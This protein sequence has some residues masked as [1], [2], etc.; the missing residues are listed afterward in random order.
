MIYVVLG[1]HKSGTTLVSR[2]LHASGIDMGDV[3]P[4]VDYDAGNKYERA[5]CLALNLEIL[6]TTTY[7]VIDLAPGRAVADERQ[8]ARMDD[9]VARCQ[10]RHADWGIKDPRLCLTYGLWR[11]HLP[12]HR[13]I[14]VYRDPAQV[15]PR[16]KWR[17]RR[18]FAVNLRRAAAYQRRWIEHNRGVLDA[19]AATDLPRIVLSYH[20]LMTGPEE[21]ARLEA[22]VGRPL[23][24]CRE[25]GLYRSR[26]RPD[27]NLK[28]AG[29]WLDVRHGLRCADV[30][31][32]LAALRQEELAAGSA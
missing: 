6:G 7:D 17:G 10:A 18:G 11:P 23:A 20:E 4:D 21:F 31:A 30:L 16:F 9:L 8:Q 1:M 15:W 24:D 27:L 5:D 3:D 29:W 12:P 2:I 32:E 28:L 25:S 13:L 26:A 22:F 19:L 14:V